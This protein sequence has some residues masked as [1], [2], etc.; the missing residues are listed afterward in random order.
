MRAL[1]TLHLPDPVESP[2]SKECRPCLVFTR[3]SLFL[4]V[5]EVRGRAATSPLQKQTQKKT[6]FCLKK[7]IYV[8]FILEYCSWLQNQ[9]DVN[10]ERSKVGLNIIIYKKWAIK[11]T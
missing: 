4:L 3:E 9:W 11:D 2:A 1:S 7:A 8:T 10:L 6:D 5:E